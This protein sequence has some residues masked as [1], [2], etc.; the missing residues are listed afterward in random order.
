MADFLIDYYFWIKA[1]HIIS[2]IAWMAGLLYLPRLF[3][4]HA[5]CDAASEKSEMLKIM[6][7]KLLRAIMNP[8]MIMAWVFGLLMLYANPALFEAAWMHAKLTCVVLM[9]ILHHVYG[10]WRKVFDND[11]NQRNHVFYRWWNEAPTVLMII[12]VVCAVVEPF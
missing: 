9:T 5:Q 8:A 2:I 12:I 4:Y 7:R 11:K 10:R 3:V 1:A 6:E